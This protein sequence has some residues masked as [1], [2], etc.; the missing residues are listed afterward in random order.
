MDVPSVLARPRGPSLQASGPNSCQV[1]VLV[2]DTVRNVCEACC[3]GLAGCTNLVSLLT[4]NVPQCQLKK[5]K[6]CIIFIIKM[7]FSI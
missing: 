4:L 6:K 1:F 7:L 5:K 2:F 3:T